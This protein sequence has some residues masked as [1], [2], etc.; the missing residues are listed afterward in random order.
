M[1]NYI[2]NDSNLKPRKQQKNQTKKQFSIQYPVMEAAKKDHLGKRL[3]KAR[4][5][6]RKKYIY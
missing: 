5:K 1:K 2:V 4:K 3:F 6:I